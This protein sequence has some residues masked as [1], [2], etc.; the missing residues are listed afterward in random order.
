MDRLRFIWIRGNSTTRKVFVY[1]D[2]IFFQFFY[3]FTLRPVIGILFKVSEEHKIIL[4]VNV[5]LH[6]IMYIVFWV[7][8]SQT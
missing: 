2:Q 8:T 5:I 6:K 1:I 3:G 4:P 7:N